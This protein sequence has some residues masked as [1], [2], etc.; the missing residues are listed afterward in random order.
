M[1]Q[2]LQQPFVVRVTAE[3][4]LNLDSGAKESAAVT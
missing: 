2:Q 3:S 1:L 4:G